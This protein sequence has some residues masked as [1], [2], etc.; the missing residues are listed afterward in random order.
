MVAILVITCWPDLALAGPCLS[1]V[2]YG[3]VWHRTCHV[4]VSVRHTSDVSLSRSPEH[5]TL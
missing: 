4:F 1:V 5:V 2:L 3:S